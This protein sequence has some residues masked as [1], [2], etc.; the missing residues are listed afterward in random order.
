MYLQPKAKQK[1][2]PTTTTTRTSRM[3][4]KMQRERER[5]GAEPN[6]YS[7]YDCKFIENAKK[8]E[9][10]IC[11]PIY[12]WL[13]SD[14]WDFI[15]D[16]QMKYNP[17]Y[18]KGY[19]R[20]GCVGCPMGTRKAIELNDFPKFKRAYKNAFKKML[21]NIAPEKIPKKW[22]DADGIYA[23]WIEDDNIPGQLTLDGTEYKG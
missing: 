11:S 22:K 21:E 14:V 23:W 7:V 15:H 5:V 12:K 20:V 8:N 4:S 19:K 10:L 9:E 13:D 2:M 6:D 16:R 1:K 17:L 18:D 3:C